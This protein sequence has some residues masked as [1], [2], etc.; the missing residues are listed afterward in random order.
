MKYF[1]FI[2][3]ILIPCS[4][5]ADDPL[6]LAKHNC[7]LDKQAQYDLHRAVQMSMQRRIDDLQSQNAELQGKIKNLEVQK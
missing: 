3:I 1:L 2:A 6:T 7:D 5:Y 4:S